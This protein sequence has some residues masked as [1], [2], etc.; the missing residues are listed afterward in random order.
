[1][2]LVAVAGSHTEDG[3][4]F[5]SYCGRFDSDTERVCSHCG[6]GVRL[7]TD[8]D[9]SI[10]PEAAFLIVREDGQVSAAS[11]AAERLLGRHLVGRQFAAIDLA[12]AQPT[13][14]PCGDPPAT[15]VVLRAA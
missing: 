15:V 2:H 5:C 11:A 14:A 4:E 1:L 13:F 7:R 8:K 12:G 10:G 3:V 6:L 9:V